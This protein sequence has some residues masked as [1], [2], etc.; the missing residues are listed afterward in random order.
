MIPLIGHLLEG[1]Y[2]AWSFLRLLDYLSVRAIG[3]ALFAFVLVLVVMPRFMWYLHRRGLVDQMRETGV[4]SSFDK[5]GTPAMGGAVMVGAILAACLV[6]CDPTNRYVWAVVAATL[7]FA[8]IGLSDD[9]AKWRSRSGNR[10]MS[11]A[12]KLLLQGAFAA[13]FAAFLASPWTPL[14]AREA[15]TLYVPFVKHALTAS[16][17]IYLPAVI[18]FVM[19][20]G[21]AVNITDGMDGLAIVP[22]VFVLV[23]LGVFAYVEG[24]AVWAKYLQY[25][26]FRSAGELT[27]FCSAFAGAGIGFLWFNAYPAQIFMGD[28]G[29]LA[30]G[31]SLATVSVLLKQEALFLILGGLFIAEALSSQI[32]DKIG[33]KL[34]G[35]RIFSRA[36]FHHQMQHDGLAETK[37]VIRLWIVSLILALAALAT[38]KVR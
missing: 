16:W 31:G 27:V 19:L 20:V 14:P 12:K 35:R 33:I 29:S 4:P 30:I 18:V 9:V 32:Q 2:R 13:L 22:S 37:V 11:E 5:A 34:L 21:N 24:N 6:W 3:A 36:P 25:P 1:G 28:T 8:G 23:V 38:L 10:G 26:L 7:W 17:W 15:S